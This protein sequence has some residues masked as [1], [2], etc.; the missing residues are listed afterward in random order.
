MYT[1]HITEELVAPSIQSGPEK[2]LT[3]NPGLGDDWDPARV[4]ATIDLKCIKCME[5][6]EM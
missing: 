5:D 6:S 2:H 1:L 4:D 3:S